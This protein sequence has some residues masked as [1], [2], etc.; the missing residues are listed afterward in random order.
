[1]INFGTIEVN[2]VSGNQDEEFIQL[3]NP[4]SIAVDISDWR[5]SGAIE[6]TFL[7]GTVLPPNGAI[8]V[9]PKAAAFRARAVSPKGGEGLLVQGGYKG[10]LSN[11]AELITL[12]DSSG[13]TN[14]TTTY[15]SQPTDAQRYLVVSEIMY[16]PPGDGLAEFIELLNISSSVT[17]DLLGVRFT[18]GVEFD[19][20]NSAITS[21]PPGGRV[22]IVRDLAAFHAA[23]GTNR[24]V[25]AF[26]RMAVRSVT[27]AK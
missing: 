14:N 5:L 26:S 20:T 27:A 21:L 23:Y 11:F 22:L 10:H 8:Y 17:L 12:I 16:H 13:A 19:F 2:P 18:Q 24:P 25:A 7:G 9:C 15:E 1:V 4:N 6:Y 3:L